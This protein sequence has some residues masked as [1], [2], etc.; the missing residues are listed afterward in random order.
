MFVST[1]FLHLWIKSVGEEE[2]M[3]ASDRTHQASA[4]TEHALERIWLVG[5]R[6]VIHST[7]IQ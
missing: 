6:G 1:V 5:Q 3:S 4:E 7:V 2:G